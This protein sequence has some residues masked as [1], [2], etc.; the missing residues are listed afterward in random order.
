MA[1]EYE[2]DDEYNVSDEC[3]IKLMWLMRMQPCSIPGGYHH[4]PWKEDTETDRHAAGKTRI[5]VELYISV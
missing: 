5:F 4:C 2:H 3:G 1:A